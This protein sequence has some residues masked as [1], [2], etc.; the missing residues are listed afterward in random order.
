[1]S[2]RSQVYEWDSCDI[3][4]STNAVGF[5]N[6]NNWRRWL[7]SRSTTINWLQVRAISNFNNWYR[8]GFPM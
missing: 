6:I 4:T 7:F 2:V 8:N 5:Y 3:N 1:M